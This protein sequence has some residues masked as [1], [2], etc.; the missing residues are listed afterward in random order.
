MATIVE[1]VD[2][3][4]IAREWRCKWS[5]DNDKVSLAQAQKVLV[6]N[7]DAIKAVDGVASVQRVVCGG[8]LDFKIVVALPAE[9]YKAWAG[10]NHPPEDKVLKELSSISGISTIETQ[11]YTLETM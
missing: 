11:T 3:E 9:K 10:V 7:M 8:C 1:G 2:F 6:S 5:A 4:T